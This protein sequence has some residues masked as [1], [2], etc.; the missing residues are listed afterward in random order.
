MA[1]R[2]PVHEAKARKRTPR[3]AET[4]DEVVVSMPPPLR[5]FDVEVLDE[6]AKSFAAPPA[7]VDPPPQAEPPAAAPRARPA[8]RT[9]F[10][11]AF[12]FFAFAFLL[13]VVI[14]VYLAGAYIFGAVTTPEAHR[15]F[16]IVLHVLTLL[17][18]L[19]AFLGGRKS[20]GWWSV[21]LFAAIEI[22]YALIA[23]HDR[24]EETGRRAFAALSAL[25]VVNALFIFAVALMLVYRNPMWRRRTA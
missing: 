20:A 24:F 8:W 9:A 25:H 5:T 19:V 12:P 2:I 14:Q 15:T 22:Q 7:P 3:P 21:G 13:G 17:M 6:D 18:I 10:S 23:A 11:K 16:V 1:R 4:G